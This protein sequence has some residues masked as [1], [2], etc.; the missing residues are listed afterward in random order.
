MIIGE[1]SERTAALT[2]EREDRLPKW[3]QELLRRLRMRLDEARK[4]AR[5]TQ[6]EGETDTFFDPYADLPGRLKPGTTVVFVL[7]KDARGED[8]YVYAKARRDGDQSYLELHGSGGLWVQGW[9]TNV[10]H[11]NVKDR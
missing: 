4:Y 10:L 5:R 3:A 8:I 11:L 6:H 2:D 9:A 1:E 7:G